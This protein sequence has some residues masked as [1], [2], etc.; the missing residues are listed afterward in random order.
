MIRRPVIVI[1]P[2]LALIAVCG[3]TAT[4]VNHQVALVS[5]TASSL[6]TGATTDPSYD[7]ANHIAEFSKDFG[8]EFWT[9]VEN[10]FNGQGEA[11]RLWAQQFCLVPPNPCQKPD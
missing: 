7:C 8:P 3:L 1:M 11:F 9:E 4:S 6:P 5:H 2:A 10:C